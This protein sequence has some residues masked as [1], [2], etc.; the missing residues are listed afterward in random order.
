LKARLIAKPLPTDMY[1]VMRSGN[2]VSGV[3]RS[4]TRSSCAMTLC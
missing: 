2:S 4:S 1:S 3:A